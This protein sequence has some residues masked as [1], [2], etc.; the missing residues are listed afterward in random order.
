M[1]HIFPLRCTFSY[2]FAQR[3]TIVLEVLQANVGCWGRRKHLKE[4]GATKLK[5]R[6][7]STS[8]FRRGY[9]CRVFHSGGT[10]V[11]AKLFSANG[12]CEAA[13]VIGGMDR[14]EQAPNA[15]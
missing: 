5:E 1:A 14:A 10:L 13:G 9:C 11:K 3:F 8:K 12:W 7:V 4:S 2:S 6:G 15:S